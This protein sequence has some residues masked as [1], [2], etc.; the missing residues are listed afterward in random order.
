M[1]RLEPGYLAELQ[2]TRRGNGSY[3][4]YSILLLAGLG[5]YHWKGQRLFWLSATLAGAVLSLG[6]YLHV[7]GQY[8]FEIAALGWLQPAGQ[9]LRQLADALSTSWFVPEGQVALPL[10]FLALKSIPG[11]WL[12]REPGRFMVVAYLGLALLAGAGLAA[13]LDK[14]PRSKRSLLA[15]AACLLVGLEYFPQV[16]SRELHP[17]PFYSQIA[18]ESEDFAV[19]DVTAPPRTLYHQSIHG[20]R[21]PTGYVGRGHRPAIEAMN[22]SGLHDFWNENLDE[23]SVHKVLQGA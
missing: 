19:L 11:L 5:V 22:K 1:G 2:R 16:S 20:K 9:L 8:Q 12:L 18:R 15:I 6:P 4:G 21:L 10:P 3:L 13:W 14:A 23:S 17:H 7:G